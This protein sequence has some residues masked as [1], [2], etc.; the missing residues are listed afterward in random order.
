MDNYKYKMVRLMYLYL[1]GEITGEE[2][3]ELQQWLEASPGNRAMFDKVNGKQRFS[4]KY[5]AYKN[6]D[7][8]AAFGRFEKQVGLRSRGRYLWLKYAAMFL[9]PLG[10]AL[11]LLLNHSCLLYTS[12]LLE[13]RR[14]ETRVLH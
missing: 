7:R 11:F 8:D 9:L 12:K 3:Q 5:E 1:S 14:I 6:I 2:K 4:S 13:V 10:V